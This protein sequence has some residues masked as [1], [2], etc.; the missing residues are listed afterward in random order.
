[1]DNLKLKILK[2]G[3]TQALQKKHVFQSVANNEF[4]GQI[5]QKGDKVVMDQVSPI[6]INSYAGTSI[7]SQSL[8]TAQREIIADQ[9]DYWSFQLDTLE[10]NNL[11]NQ[12]I[13]EG[14]KNAAYAANDTI[15]AYIAA[16]YAQAGIVQNTNAAPVDMTSLNVEDEFLKMAEAF[17]DAG[18]PRG[19]RK[20][21]IIPPWVTTKLT[22]A[23]IAA[24]T[25]NTGLYNMG[26]FTSALG[27]DF[28]ESSN[29][30]KNSTSWDKTRIICGVYGQSLGFASAVST[31][32]TTQVEDLIG[33]T[34]VKGRFV[35]GAKAV[36]P[37]ML[38]V[39]YADKTAEA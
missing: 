9:D 28:L 7:T 32:E 6:T 10:Y 13:N 11:K 23:G 30:S 17:A 12:I 8:F 5:N 24:K 15:D 25:D 31:V 22:L 2:A 36:R 27:W 18:I 29:V 16:L 20:F 34:K 1:M 3:F 4:S 35:F 26:Y 38:G 19:L 14:M 39:L 33:V 21:A 37:D